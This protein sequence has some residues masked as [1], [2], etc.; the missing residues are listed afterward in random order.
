M[1]LEQYGFER[2]DLREAVDAFKEKRK[3]VYTGL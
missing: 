1:A 2:R 3:P